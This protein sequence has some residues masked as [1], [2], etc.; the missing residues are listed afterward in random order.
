MKVVMFASMIVQKA[1]LKPAFT[2]ASGDFPVRCSSLIR[3]KI[4][5]LASTAIPTV[6]MRPAMLVRVNVRL[7]ADRIATTMKRSRRSPGHT[8]FHFHSCRSEHIPGQ[9]DRPCR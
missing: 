5:T 2:E 7:K 6:R 9:P 3:S 1:F 4:I 8:P